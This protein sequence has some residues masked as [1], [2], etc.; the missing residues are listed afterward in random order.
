MKKPTPEQVERMTPEI[1]ERYEKKLK[2]V[3][4]NRRILAGFV[5]VIIAA[6]ICLALSMTVL[7]N[8]TSIKVT[9]KGNFYDEKEIISASGLDV[10]ENMLR[11]N[12]AEAEQRIEKMLPYVLDAKIKKNA[13]G[14]VS[15]SVTDDTA[16]IIFEAENGF[17]VA[18]SEGKVLEVLKEEPEKSNLA[19]LRT[20][21]K[22]KA[23]PG[24]SIGF[25]DE[26]EAELYDK[27]VKAL[28]AS[29]LYESITGIDI[30]K[31]A[32]IKVEYQHRMRIKL[33]NIS[34]IDSK[35]AAAAKTIEMENENNPNTIAE[36][37][38]TIPKKVYV[39]P[40]DSLDDEVNAKKEKR[41]DETEEASEESTENKE[42]EST[43]SD[44]EA[45]E[46]ETEKTTEKSSEKA[47]VENEE[48]TTKKAESE[49]QE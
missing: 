6:A 43:G 30:S 38:A 42:E 48:N 41:I 9:K 11:T 34:E 14:A 23:V 1:R 44:S 20:S 39:N 31:S 46:E 28:K 5:A 37:N 49:E 7:F 47:D 4:R 18:D 12:F 35:L 36:V 32:N 22:A 40:L 45:D 10:G 17:A 24:E 15:I 13:S 25:A 19:W 2:K 29:G 26:K 3:K 33:G 27:L 8:I 16:V 21:K